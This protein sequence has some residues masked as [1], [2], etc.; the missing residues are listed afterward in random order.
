MRQR[1]YI[2][3]TI[4]S[5]YYNNRSDERSNVCSKWTRY[6]WDRCSHEYDLVTSGA[7]L[8]ELDRGNHPDKEKKLALLKVIA[9]L[10]P[11]PLVDQAAETYVKRFLMPAGAYGDAVHMAFASVYN[12]D[13]LLTWNC[14][15]LAN[16]RK[17][18]HLVAV[19]SELDLT[20]PLVLTPLQLL[21]GNVYD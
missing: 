19:N 3:T 4:P 12:C 1:V 5:F 16:P 9:L 18:A 11:R 15:H 20:V 6:W 8:G 21:E 2:E 13:I 14:A 7:V 10:L 17:N